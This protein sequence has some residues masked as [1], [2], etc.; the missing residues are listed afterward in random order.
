LSA[1]AAFTTSQGQLTVTLTNLL[2]PAQIISAGQALSDVSF[3]LS[4]AAGTVGATSASGQLGN[5]AG[6]TPGIVADISGDPTRWLGAGGQGSF[7]VSGNTVTLETIG[8]GQPTEMIL[9][10][11]A[12]GGAYANLNSS[13]L[14]FNPS[15]IGPATFTLALSG[16]TG[17]TTITGVTFSFGTGPDTFIPVGG[18]PP[19]PVPEP[20]SIA[21]LGTG[22]AGLAA[23][24]RRRVRIPTA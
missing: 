19:P 6:T 1:S 13:V 21:L 14:N 8:G 7:S 24:V 17:D 20:T 16:V 4:N 11:V 5:I 18:N 3:N 22:M 2:T 12:N 9:P 23:I 15:V 10:F